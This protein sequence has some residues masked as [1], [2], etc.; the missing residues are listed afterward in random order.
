MTSPRSSS[1][2]E[3]V[4]GDY[5]TFTAVLTSH[6]AL[7]V[8]DGAHSAL[9]GRGVGAEEGAEGASEVRIVLIKRLYCRLCRISAAYEC[10]GMRGACT[11][12]CGCI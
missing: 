2:H 1:C 3:A 6:R 7:P 11:F 12:V 9:P 4:L 10:V 5:S 8:A